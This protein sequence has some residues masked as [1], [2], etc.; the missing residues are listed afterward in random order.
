M[1]RETVSTIAKRA[2]RCQ[3][4]YMAVAGQ[5]AI[6]LACVGLECSGSANA[7]QSVAFYNDASEYRELRVTTVRVDGHL[8]V[9]A[10]KKDR[11]PRVTTIG[12]D[13]RM[14]FSRSTTGPYS[15][16]THDPCCHRRDQSFADIT[17][18][19]TCDFQVDGG[20]WRQC[21]LPAA[22]RNSEMKVGISA[23]MS[24]IVYAGKL[25]R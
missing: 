8:M 1:K 9:C 13:P 5:F 12:S 21:I 22:D 14:V 18:A 3:I 4:N 25:E 7:M 17:Q 16:W 24:P 2:K 19:V 6:I 15:L 23:Y 10:D 20:E 11:E